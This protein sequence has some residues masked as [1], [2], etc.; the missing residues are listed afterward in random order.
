M[1]DAPDN[2]PAPPEEEPKPAE[3]SPEQQP[4]PQ[5]DQQAP[6]D[7][8]PKNHASRRFAAIMERARLETQRAD[9]AE[10]RAKR[11]EELLAARNG[12]GDGEDKPASGQQLTREQILAEARRIVAEERLAERRNTI[13]QAGV[14]EFGT[15]AWN[16]KSAVLHAMG[17][18]D[19]P[20]F[21]EALLDQ[22]DAHQLIATLADD[23]D[24]LQA[25]LAKRPASMA[26][27]IG[28][29]AAEMNAQTPKPEISKAP[30]PIKPLTTARSVPPPDPAKMTE[31]E[32]IEYRNRTAPK[33]LGGKGIAA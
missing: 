22:D 12:G 32:Y 26:A 20:D 15:D 1:T 29:L 28:R 30:A 19:R 13:V 8:A 10:A 7:D 18:L 31:R 27:A 4:E 5:A 25:I 11:L 33:H 17:A 21:M 14:K 3:A 24:Q 2:D 6:K 23:P 16:E 9:E